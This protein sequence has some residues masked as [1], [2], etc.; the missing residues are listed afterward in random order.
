[1]NLNLFCVG[2]KLVSL[3]LKE[4]HPL[5]VFKNRVVR[6]ILRAMRLKK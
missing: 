2:V 6:E 4:G 3:T 5:R 1:M